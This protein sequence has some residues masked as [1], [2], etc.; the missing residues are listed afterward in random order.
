MPFLNQISIFF[1]GGPLDSGQALFSAQAGDINSRLVRAAIFNKP[2]FWATAAVYDVSALNL[3]IAYEYTDTAGTK[4]H[5]PQYA[6]T[7]VSGIV[8]NNVVEF[9]IPNAPLAQKGVVKA[10]ITAY[11]AVAQSQLNSAVFLFQVLTSLMVGSADDPNIPILLQL[12]TTVQQLNTALTAAETQRNATVS[13]VVSSLGAGY[14]W[15][16]VSGNPVVITP[17]PE[18][19]LHVK[20]SGQYTQAGS[21]DPS[22]TNIRAI[23]PWLASGATAT[24]NRYGKNL[25][26]PGV[27]STQNG[28]TKTVAFDGTITLN[29]TASAI[30]VFSVPTTNPNGKYYVSVVNPV[31]NAGVSIRPSGITNLLDMTLD[32]I[33]KKGTLMA[34]D[35]ATFSMCGVRIASG[36]VLSN[37]TLKIQIE[38]G[39]SAS[40]YEQYVAPTAVDL[41][42]PADIWNGYIGND[43]VAANTQGVFNVTTCISVIDLGTVLKCDVLYPTGY[44]PSVSVDLAAKCSHFV[45][46]AVYA[47]DYEHFYGD[48]GE[49]RVYINKAR[50]ASNNVAGVNAWL[51]GQLSAGTP[52][53]LLVTPAVPIAYTLTAAALA[54]L[55]QA[56]RITPRQ[57]VLT[58]S[59]GTLTVQDAKS[60]IAESDDQKIRLTEK[61]G[62]GVLSGLGV[63][64]QSTPNMTVSVA[65]GICYLQN[66]T[67]YAVQSNAALA[68]SAA[69]ATNP[70]IDIVYVSSLGVVSYLAGTAAASPVAPTVPTDGLL[71]A[72]VSVA[73]N[74]TA[75]TTAMITSKKKTLNGEDWITPTL[76]N[77]AT[78]PTPVAYRKDVDGTVYLRG[79]FT[80]PVLEVAVFALPVGYR[81]STNEL[82]YLVYAGS[83]T[84]TLFGKIRVMADGGV[85]VYYYGTNIS[86][87]SICFKADQ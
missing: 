76:L 65:S 87:A 81:P 58:T 38:Y 55:A 33:N 8:E 43:G 53:Q 18:S 52:V 34:T 40:A 77:G 24:V 13:A 5:T 45:N 26:N 46:T 31:A 60:L 39:E 64:A 20:V 78:A 29:G 70:R 84:N 36:T 30:T 61:T 80:A 16:E 44:A 85:K 25:F 68:V 37:F 14:L 32:A 22:P 79:V 42:A 69:D 75:I 11:D 66:G 54:A 35:A 27:G 56:D 86:L 9:T 23:T 83:A 19:P 6:C 3:Q 15:R 12:I 7:L 21:G 63:T 51:A 73:A 47:G 74:V 2:N 1:S 48:S 62:Y 57:N 41:T 71:L 59:T 17:V 10:Q 82:W 72:L 28:I 50:L 4:Q 49:V 67:R